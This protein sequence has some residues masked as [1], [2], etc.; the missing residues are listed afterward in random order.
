MK[1]CCITSGPG[2]L[3]HRIKDLRQAI[4]VILHFL[5]GT[6]RLEDPVSNTTLNSCG[7]VPIPMVP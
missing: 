4:S 2:S 3:T 1:K 5:E 7:G 6:H